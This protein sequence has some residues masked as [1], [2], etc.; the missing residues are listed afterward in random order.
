MAKFCPL[1]SSSGG[2]AIYIGSGE[3]GILIDVGMNCKRTELA[4][5][6]IG[7]D[8]DS[9][10][11]VFVTHEHSDHIGGLKVFA[12]KHNIPVYATEGTLDALTQRD[13][14]KPE[15][16]INTVSFD[17]NEISSLL[18]KPF[19]TSHDAKESCGYV[20]LT[21]DG[22]K[23]AVCTDLGTVTDEVESAVSGCDLVLL[24]SNHDVRM[25]ENGPY[26]YPLIQR[27]KSDKGHLSNDSC[28]ELAVKLI[29]SGTT[30]LI[31]GHL[32][33]RNN[34]PELAYTTTYSALDTAGAKEDSDYILKVAKP[35]W[36]GKALML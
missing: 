35:V 11:A 30:R 24:E 16:E 13:Y 31:L 23:I 33:E 9:V 20:V 17:G 25:L 2:N 4:L 21:P 8:P 12:A 32:S 1:F 5:Y 19:R 28:S 34:F 3:D 18:V 10:K 6:G 26:P 36:D 15:T 14:I 22:R 7:V 27:I 29:K